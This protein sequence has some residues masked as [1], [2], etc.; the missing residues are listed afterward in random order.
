MTKLVSTGHPCRFCR[1]PCQSSP[2]PPFHDLHLA[3]DLNTQLSISKR[4]RY[5]QKSSVCAAYL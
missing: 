4:L 1:D 3:F 5:S 2:N